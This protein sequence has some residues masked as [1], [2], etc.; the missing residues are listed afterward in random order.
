MEAVVERYGGA[1]NLHNTDGIYSS[2]LL[3]VWVSRDVG[4]FY[5]P[6]LVVEWR[7]S[8]PANLCGPAGLYTCHP[9]GPDPAWGDAEL[10]STGW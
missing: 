6:H 9:S 7:V 8:S 1:N 2:F 3:A 5:L 4:N 10:T